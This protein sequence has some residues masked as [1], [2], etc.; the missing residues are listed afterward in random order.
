MQ[1]GQA[2]LHCSAAR[3]SKPCRCA[4]ASGFSGRRHAVR[5]ARR[6]HRRQ[7]ASM[8]FTCPNAAARGGGVR[9]RSGRPARSL[10][11]HP[12]PRPRPRRRRDGQAPRDARPRA[13]GRFS[14]ALSRE[15][16]RKQMENVRVCLTSVEQRLRDMDKM[17]MDI[18]AISP[19]PFH[20]MY[21]LPAGAGGQDE[22]GGE[23]APGRDRP[24][25]SRPVRGPGPRAA[26]GAR[27]G[28]RRARVLREA[29]RLPGLRDRHQHRRAP[30]SRAGAISSGRRRRTST[31]WSSCTPTASP[32]ATGWPTTTSPT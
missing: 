18:Q 23:R 27:R 26:A 7:E 16:N 13:G 30:R 25:P 3:R 11:R 31:W 17:G 24:G 29:A 15:T 28:R 5:S 21:W 14:N 2:R 1:Y 32:R 6:R 19:S 20:F 12:L 10:R 9:G 4:P 22:P 8:L